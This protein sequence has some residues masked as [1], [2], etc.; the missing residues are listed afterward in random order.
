VGNGSSYQMGA[1]VFMMEALQQADVSGES[2]ADAYV[3]GGRNGA[4]AMNLSSIGAAFGGFFIPK[5]FGSSLT[6]FNSF[7]PAFMLFIAFYA[8]STVLAWVHY[9]RPGAPMRC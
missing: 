8:L 5:S 9:S 3:R 1:K 6:W 4:L 2:A 7:A